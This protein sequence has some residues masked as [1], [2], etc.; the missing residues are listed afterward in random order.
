MNSNDTQQQSAFKCRASSVGHF[1]LS[2]L[3]SCL[4]AGIALTTGG[5]VVVAILI[6]TISGGTASDK[7]EP[8]SILKISLSGVM[9]ERQG[10]NSL[11][12]LLGESSPTLELN[13][14]LRALRIAKTD[15][16]IKGISIEAGLLSADPASI[17]ELHEA[18]LDFKK[19]K[20]IVWA[21]ADHYTQGSYII[22]SAADHVVVNTI[23]G[24]SW[25]GL[26]SQTTFYTDLLAKLG[27]RMQVF[28]VGT[29]K[30]AVEPYT[31][32]QM[33]QANREQ[34]ESF[35]GDIWTTFVAKVADRRKIPTQQLQALADQYMGLAPTANLKEA[36]L[37]DDATYRDQYEKQLK[38]KLGIGSKEELSV[39]SPAKLCS[40]TQEADSKQNV[41]GVLFVQGDIVDTKEMGLASEVSTDPATMAK[42]IDAL[43]TDSRIKA[44]VVRI[45][46]G[47]GSAFASEQIWHSL[48]TLQATKPVVVSMGGM[49]ASG[50]Y[51]IAMAS[52]HIV[53][54]PTTLTG[55]IGIFGL[56]PD[57]SKLLNDKI[58]LKFDIVKTNAMADIGNISRPF[59]EKESKLMQDYVEDGYRL[60]L[61][62]VADGRKLS[63]AKTDS[64]AQGRVWTG[65]QAKQLGLVDQLGSLQDA[66]AYAAKKAK[67][68]NDYSTLDYPETEPWYASLGLSDMK[69]QMSQQMLRSTIGNYSYALSVINKLKKQN[70]IQARIPYVIKID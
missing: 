48:K 9:T 55:S 63:I 2:M 31:Q 64:L 42:A 68:D 12:S 61:Q 27:V 21:Y 18:L 44:V 54:Q 50:A 25:K 40:A 36:H 29:F 65:R 30:S 66:I 10:G 41:I 3:S 6:S 19:S 32:S 49:A 47:G 46:S 53:A 33:S 56:V 69:L 22:C 16:R 26:S 35:L 37:V 5:L 13:E 59:N 1:F 43:R 23:G 15:D 8:N 34:V 20:K 58:G 28:R 70:R 24:V 67:L 39:V 45:N 52:D 62:R 11:A 57:V 51:Y 14:L 7:I 60:F 38:A 4:G 17:E